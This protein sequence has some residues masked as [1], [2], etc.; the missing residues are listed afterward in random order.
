MND[1]YGDQ[2][3]ISI[4]DLTGIGD[5]N[6]AGGQMQVSWSDITEMMSRHEALK[7]KKAG[8]CF[9]PAK[10]KAEDKWQLSEPKGNAR[11]HKPTFRNDSNVESISFAV[12]DLDV[13]GAREKA[14]ALFRDFDYVL[15]S[16]FSHTKD[17]PYKFRIV[18]RLEEPVL[19]G[20]WAQ[21]FRAMAAGVNADRS[22]GNFSRL[23]FYPSYSKNAGV[24][25]V[26]E[27]N[28]GRSFGREDM[29]AFERRFGTH[30]PDYAKNGEDSPW[31]ST[32][33]T[34]R[35]F[36]GRRRTADERRVDEI[37]HSYEAYLKRHEAIVAECLSGIGESRH[38]FAL[39]AIGREFVLNK[40]DTNLFMLLQFIYRA[41]QEKSSKALYQGDTP[42]EL[43]E[44]V[45]SAMAKFGVGAKTDETRNAITQ[46]INRAEQ[47]AI[48]ERWSFPPPNT[49]RRSALADSSKPS[50]EE[51]RSQHLRALK[52]LQLTG[53]PVEFAR[54]VMVK[55]NARSGRDI[56][57]EHCVQFVFRAI[58]GME[59]SQGRGGKLADSI[60]TYLGK[61]I[62]SK[63]YIVDGIN[64]KVPKPAAAFEFSSRL[65][66]Q[67][68]SG[69]R[70]WKILDKKKPEATCDLNLGAS[71]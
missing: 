58:A 63:D 70:P 29:L 5:D 35:H 44:M 53:D 24:S 69:Q 39:R 42:H 50:Y 54:A 64:T 48:T 49:N 28:K 12:L 1:R 47:C 11:K 55:E 8:L 20:E 71:Q 25:P 3:D 36:S 6:I 61:L 26:F 4:V 18:I 51:M 23:F 22:C 60:P 57:I 10:L 17:S 38:N 9:I 67:S 15:Y 37:D 13:P 19:V 52:G 59:S 2:A 27:Q 65:A 16:T 43:Q 68:A 62:T 45:E 46:L 21:W 30:V 34:Q 31:W 33:D 41:A 56:D 40:D 66:A 7:D 32:G 14:V